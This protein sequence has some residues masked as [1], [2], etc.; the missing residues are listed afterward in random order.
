MRT[1]TTT[2]RQTL[3]GTQYRVSARVWVEDSAGTLRNLSTLGGLDWVDEIQWDEDIDQPVSQ[4]TVRLWRETDTQSLAPLVEA[5]PLNRANGAYTPLLEAGRELVVEVATTPVGAEAMAADWERVFH[6]EIDEVDWGGSA[7]KVSLV[8]RDLGGRLLDRFIEAEQKY[9]TAEGVAVETVMQKILDDT[10]GA[11]AV[12][13]YSPGGTPAAPFRADESPGWKIKEFKQEKEPLLEGLRKL[14]QQ[15][16]WDVRYRWNEGSGA[17]RLTFFEPGRANTAADWTFG[18]SSYLDVASLRTTRAGVRNVV[19]VVYTDTADGKRKTVERT[20]AASISRYGRRF[21]ELEEESS[22]LIDTAEEAGRL[23][24]S[25]LS[26]LADPKAEQEIELHFF[27]PAE[28]G[29]LYR[30]TANGVHYDTDQEL[31]T[32]GVRHQLTRDQQRTTIRVRGRVAGAY[33]EWLRR[34]IRVAGEA[35]LPPGSPILAP[36]AVL[37]ASRDASDVYVHIRSD[38]GEFSR[39]YVVDDGTYGQWGLVKSGTDATP[40]YVAPNATVGPE[41]WFH[42][43]TSFTRKLS[44][45]P[46]RRDQVRRVSLQGQAQNSG[47]ASAWVS[48]ALNVREQPWLESVDLIWDETTDTLTMRAV[49]GAFCQS[50]RIEVST[51]E[52]FATGV[53]AAAAPLTDLGGST[54]VASVP[55]ALTAAD[56]G[57]K[58]HG[59]VTP[60]NGPL[61]DTNADGAADSPSGLAGQAQRDSEFVPAS[62]SGAGIQPPA[63]DITF[64][65]GSRTAETVRYAGALG[66]GGSG[67]LQW[68]RRIDSDVA[69]GTFGALSSTLP[70]D[71]TIQRDPFWTRYVLLRVVDAAGRET[72]AEYPIA[73]SMEGV[74]TDG[75]VH[76]L[77]DDQR[78]VTVTGEQASYGFRLWD[79]SDPL[80]LPA[81]QAEYASGVSVASL[82]PAQAGADVTGSNTAADTSRVA[83]TLAGVVRSDATVG[84]QGAA[85]VADSLLRNGG[86]QEDADGAPAGGWVAATWSTAGSLLRTTTAQARLGDRSLVLDHPAAA[87]AGAYQDLPVADGDVVEV[88]GWIKTTALPAAD[89]G[90]GVAI[91]IDRLAG[92]T[93]LASLE[94]TSA[95]TFTTH[96]PEGVDVGLPGDG[97]A[98]DWTFVRSLFRVEG[99]GSIRVHLHLGYGGVQSGTAW[100]DGLSVRRRT[101]YEVEGAVR[102]FSLLDPD[103][104]KDSTKVG[105]VPSLQVRSD[106]QT[107]RRGV[108]SEADNLI[109]NG[110]GQDGLAGWL[111]FPGYQ[112][113]TVDT[114]VAR[115]GDRSLAF[116]I[117]TGVEGVVYQDY[118]VAD[119][120]VVEV[121][122][123]VK[124]S[125][126]PAADPGQG[127]VLYTSIVSGVTTLELLERDT[128]LVPT[129]HNPH[130]VDVGLP[131]DGVAR[132]W[133]HVR[134]LFRVR[135]SGELRLHL[136]L[137]YGSYQTGQAWF[138]GIAVRR[139]TRYEAEGRRRTDT[140]YGADAE[141]RSGILLRDHRNVLHSMDQNARRSGYGLAPVDDTGFGGAIAVNAP[142]AKLHPE[143]RFVDQMY[144][145]IKR[146]EP[147]S[148]GSVLESEAGAETR[149]VSARRDNWLTNPVFARWP[150]GQGLPDGWLYVYGA[151]IGN[152]QRDTRLG[153]VQG[154]LGMRWNIPAGTGDIIPNVDTPAQL[155]EGQTHLYVEADVYLG[156]GDF[157]GSGIHVQ[158]FDYNGTA[159]GV[160]TNL[161]FSVVGATPAADRV[162]RVRKVLRLPGGAMHLARIHAMPAWVGFGEPRTAKD[163]SILRI[164]LRPATDQ[165]VRTFRAITGLASPTLRAETTILDT[166]VRARAVAKGVVVGSCRDGDQVNYPDGAYQN[167]PAIAFG[168][169]GI[170][171][172]PGLGTGGPQQVVVQALNPT[173][174]GF[175]ALAKIRQMTGAVNPYTTSFVDAGAVEPRYQANRNTGGNVLDNVFRYRYSVTIH[176]KPAFSDME[177]TG[178]AVDVG[179]WYNNGGG[180]L[181]A[182]VDYLDN[183]TGTIQ[184]YHRDI[185]L[186][187]AGIDLNDD[188]GLHVQA[189]YDK[190]GSLSPGSVYYEEVAAPDERP[191]TPSGAS[192]IPFTA[193]GA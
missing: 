156:S 17:F 133:T 30:F 129:G 179:L 54:P 121:A 44:A 69:Q 151:G 74:G 88:S 186:G 190:G 169:G 96:D 16:G 41:S 11:G 5:S 71:E 65:S 62:E 165:E 23:A 50:A 68:Q 145:R 125:A 51:D 140:F 144:G 111:P 73:P 40:R 81:S 134:V 113:A 137:G 138:D 162:Y 92:V 42:D 37:T 56:R 49:G 105:G 14:A 182:H 114:A 149:V 120:D 77:R 176:S 112:N 107:G 139:H 148:D 136:L 163:I 43:G 79:V 168:G 75:L 67:P 193:V 94:R 52:S 7:S 155:L 99:T 86:G 141:L 172:H 39:L 70:A 157:S 115:F 100:F 6:G 60:Y 171:F 95:H 126:L 21:M 53:R 31:A 64:V 110:G 183:Y 26:D 109:A 128:V 117:S 185:A 78:G 187:L 80:R 20:H 166:P 167:P 32:V 175:T 85:A 1:L 147:T 76:T 184:S 108:G 188:F 25:A 158:I 13:L 61:R 130:G 72:L 116:A 101:R 97:V 154:G 123:W 57:R 63:A 91:N 170:T 106:A 192:S 131:A 119:G 2:Q 3:A 104:L 24:D 164:T 84:R 191:M 19:R 10:L 47:A 45:I 122:G 161:H 66:A 177:N 9:G 18:P 59:R 178:G 189:Q 58:W 46:L 143:L 132:D 135:G 153:H 34:E 36:H 8:A 93:K 35:E 48:V 127:A 4:V 89:A 28:L 12:V 22:S 174:S 33:R 181:M 55:F 150:A 118:R 98:R 173:A 124:T 102:T 29:D 27:W 38:T 15:V 83:G 82:R 87:D 146:G 103:G 159:V 152:P 90:Q 180:W 142:L 160:D